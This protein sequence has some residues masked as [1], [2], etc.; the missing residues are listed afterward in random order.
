MV[1]SASRR[2]VGR[3]EHTYV[4][5]VHVIYTDIQGRIGIYSRKRGRE[6]E[7]ENEDHPHTWR[8]TYT[9]QRAMCPLVFQVLSVT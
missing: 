4:V 6:R 9:A 1:R 7:R 8:C 2:A 3:H 5:P